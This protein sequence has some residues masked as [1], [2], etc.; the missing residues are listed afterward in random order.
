[1]N[2]LVKFA[3]MQRMFCVTKVFNA[4]SHKEK[5]LKALKEIV[6]HDLGVG[7]GFILG[8]SP[9]ADRK[10]EHMLVE[11][12]L[13][14]RRFRDDS[15]SV[16][17]GKGEQDAIDRGRGLLELLQGRWNSPTLCHFCTGPSCPCGGSR[18]TAAKT[19]FDLIAWLVVFSLPATPSFSRCLGSLRSKAVAW[20]SASARQVSNGR[21]A[22]PLL[23]DVY[24]RGWHRKGLG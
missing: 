18:E 9:P 8:Q 11:M 17:A 2:V 1:M 10:C 7:G 13:W 6:D 22:L 5:V 21:V 16:F 19:I 23:L 3:F 15:G 12:L 24:D 14:R 20:R 4:Q